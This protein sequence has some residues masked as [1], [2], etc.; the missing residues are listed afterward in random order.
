MKKQIT[1]TNK[2][3]TN[4]HFDRGKIH[5]KHDSLSHE[6]LFSTENLKIESEPIL[7]DFDKNVKEDIINVD[8][9]K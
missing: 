9:V 5:L 8:F 1:P 7:I 6:P 2:N 3:F 4:Y